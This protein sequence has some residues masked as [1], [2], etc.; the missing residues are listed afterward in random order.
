MQTRKESEA[1]RRSDNKTERG[2]ERKDAGWGEEMSGKRGGGRRLLAA[3]GQQQAKGCFGGSETSRPTGPTA[4]T[5][6]DRYFHNSS[7]RTP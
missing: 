1:N 7:R 2:R 4:S 6:V 3:R 5:V